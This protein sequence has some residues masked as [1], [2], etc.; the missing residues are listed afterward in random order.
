MRL[1]SKM[2]FGALMK[3]VWSSHE[4]ALPA[5]RPHA[6]LSALTVRLEYRLCSPILPLW[7]LC[8]PIVFALVKDQAPLVF[9]LVRIH[10]SCRGPDLAWPA[11]P[12]LLVVL[13]GVEG[14]CQ[15][16]RDVGIREA[17]SLPARSL[18]R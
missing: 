8:S 11:E 3:W 16:P 2:C 4:T 18:H 13:S 1:F 15:I 14:A 5:V 7:G 9:K 10:S 17:F 12:L 6:P